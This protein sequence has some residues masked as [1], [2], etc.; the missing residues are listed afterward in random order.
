LRL[1]GKK[2]TAPKTNKNA[3]KK[4]TGA[5][6]SDATAPPTAEVNSLTFTETQI[7]KSKKLDVVKE[8][9][10]N[11]NKRSASFVVVG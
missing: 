6:S 8:F 10:D 3:A 1:A 7:P 5:G 2:P 11:K 4:G 9:E